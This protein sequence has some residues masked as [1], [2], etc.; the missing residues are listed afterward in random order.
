MIKEGIHYCDLCKKNKN[1]A[2][3]N[4]FQC[5]KDICLKHGK[6]VQND[7]GKWLGYLCNNCLKEDKVK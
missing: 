1:R 3:T 5:G 4:C 6:A 2:H 7:E